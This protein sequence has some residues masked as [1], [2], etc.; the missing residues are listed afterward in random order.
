MDAFISYD[1]LPIESGG[2]HSL[3]KKKWG[4]VYEECVRFL[5]TYTNNEGR[6]YATLTFFSSEHRTYKTMPSL[7]KLT[8]RYGIPRSRRWQFVDGNRRCY[9]WDLRSVKD[10]DDALQLLDAFEKFPPNRHGPLMVAFMWR[11]YFIDPGTGEVLPGQDKIPHVRR[12]LQNSQMHLM[13]AQKSKVSVWFAFPFEKWDEQSK[14][15]IHVV[16]ESMPFKCSDKH[17]RFWRYSKNGN[18]IPKVLN[19]DD[20]V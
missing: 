17:W 4:K 9:T 12:P 5:E 18:W 11:F 14:S 19:I 3:G 10:V 1:G 2:T 6:D 15:Y 13:L 7:W 20:P 8:K 16:A